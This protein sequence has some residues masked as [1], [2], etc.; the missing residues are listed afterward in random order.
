MDS[1]KPIDSSNLIQN[2]QP[3]I[4]LITLF[5]N[6]IALYDFII[7]TIIIT[8]PTAYTRLL[9]LAYGAGQLLRQCLPF[10][11]RGIFCMA[12][13]ESQFVPR[14]ILP[15]LSRELEQD[16][17]SESRAIFV[18]WARRSCYINFRGPNSTGVTVYGTLQKWTFWCCW[19]GFF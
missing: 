8:R 1:L 2:F 16:F 5:S 12:L 3:V 15:R 6:Q 13:V 11:F 9:E 19:L 7:M 18:R 4:G 17:A 14:K 10:F